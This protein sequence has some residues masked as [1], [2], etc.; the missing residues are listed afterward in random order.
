ME[1]VGAVVGMAMALATVKAG[2]VA[3]SRFDRWRDEIRFLADD[4]RDI[5]VRFA[6]IA[7]E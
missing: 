3:S 1:A 5:A 4:R 7:S 2:I 6:R